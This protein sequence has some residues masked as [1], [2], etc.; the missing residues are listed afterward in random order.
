M[1]LVLVSS[2]STLTCGLSRSCQA[3]AEPLVTFIYGQTSRT[4][5]RVMC[6]KLMDDLS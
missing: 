6:V 5:G 1:I 3:R 2:T 4:A